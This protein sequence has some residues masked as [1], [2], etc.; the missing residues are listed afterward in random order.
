M[1]NREKM[2]L[3]AF[4]E[5]VER[6]LDACSADELRTILRAMAWETP[7]LE[8]QAFLEKLERSE[9]A[10]LASRQAVQQEELL[11]D[12][13][14]VGRELKA[15]MA[16]AD[17]WEERY[18]WDEHYD[19]E[20]SLGP[21]EEFVAPLSELFDRTEAAFDYGDLPLARAA[22][23]KLFEL[24]DVEDD[25]GRGVRGSDLTGVDMEEARFRYLRA[26]YETES[27]GQ[28]PRALFEQM[29]QMRPWPARSRPMLDDLIQI[30]PRPL[31][32]REVFL[33][34]WLAFMQ[35]QAG[36]DADAW[37]REAVRLTQ[38]TQ[39]L[40]ALA[41]T[42]GQARPRAYLDWFTALAEE[43][44]HGEILAAA[45]E[46]LDTL[47][48]GLPIRAAIADHLYAA[49]SQVGDPEAQRAA[50]WEAFLVHPTLS[51][52]LDLWDVAATD[53]ERKKIMQRAVQHIQEYL[54]HPPD[55]PTVA[56]PPEDHLESQVWIDA[57]VLAHAYLL[58][59]D[60]E[61]VQQL[62]A[63][64]QVLGWSSR[65]NVQGLVVAAFLVLLSDEASGTL[66][67]NVAQIWQWGLENSTGYR[68]GGD[69]SVRQ[70]LEAAYAQRLGETT[71]PAETQEEFLAWCLE[72]TRQRVDAIVSNQ[73]RGSYDQAAVLTAACAEALRT[74]GDRQAADTF[75]GEIRNR[76]PR[77]RAFQA[78]LKTATRRM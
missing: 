71:L 76:F 41:R 70:H 5:A 11:D 10:T 38:G 67:A 56:W 54:A 57:S 30:S 34:D 78:E 1:S 14:D 4:W 73:N 18:E 13:D 62:A 23:R 33:S 47:A 52:L 60:F 19:E 43:G 53:A 46:A 48:P 75:V 66:P 24:M 29:Q 45:G 22:Y 15:A 77:H 44:K 8:R 39:G 49:A 12:I 25:Y 58:A 32:D 69:V 59:G 42:K 68:V 21:Y 40:E 65:G 20:D 61:A 74:R 2:S 63:G 64:Q 36:A 17:A 55:R 7:P 50:R 37:L 31:P 6:R 35:A 3:K 28:R 26:A 16:N 9:E 27:P 51:R 72:V